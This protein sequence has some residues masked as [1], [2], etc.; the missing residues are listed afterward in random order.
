MLG[1]YAICLIALAFLFVRLPYSVPFILA[2]QEITGSGSIIV[3]N[4]ATLTPTVAWGLGT[5][6]STINTGGV[7]DIKSGGSYLFTSDVGI[8]GSGGLIVNSGTFGKTGGVGA[9]VV[10]AALSNTS[11]T[12]N[13]TSGYINDTAGVSNSGTGSITGDLYMTGDRK[14]VV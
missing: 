12:I 2:A 14:S 5:S 4:G 9:S 3:G 1:V 13:I 7:L 8:D 11:G 10:S 6:T